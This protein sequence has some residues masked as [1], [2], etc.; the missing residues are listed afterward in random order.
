MSYNQLMLSYISIKVLDYL[1]LKYIN[2]QYEE[3]NKIYLEY[4]N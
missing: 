1:N 3:K 4:Q 2:K